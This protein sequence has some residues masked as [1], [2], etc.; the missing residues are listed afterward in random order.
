MFVFFFLLKESF[1]V[2]KERKNVV[3][4]NSTVT[5]M[6]HCQQTDHLVVAECSVILVTF[7]LLV[8]QFHLS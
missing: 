4:W 6:T 8:L 5:D 2:I 1:R 7:L 3:L